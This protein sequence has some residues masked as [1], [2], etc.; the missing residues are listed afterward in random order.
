[1]DIKVSKKDAM[2]ILNWLNVFKHQCEDPK[3]G[4]H[5]LVEDIEEVRKNFWEEC[6]QY[7]PEP[8]PDPKTKKAVPFGIVEKYNGS[9]AYCTGMDYWWIDKK[10]LRK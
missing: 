1:M 10:Y 8:K 5:H 4:L 2:H 6:K 7:F 9:A 3:I